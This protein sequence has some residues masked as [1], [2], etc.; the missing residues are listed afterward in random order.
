MKNISKSL[1]MLLTHREK[2]F[3]TQCKIHCWLSVPPSYLSTALRR[4]AWHQF[5]SL[6]H[7]PS[8][9]FDMMPLHPLKTRHVPPIV[10]HNSMFFILQL[11]PG[12][13]QS[14]PP[15]WQGQQTCYSMLVRQLIG[16]KGTCSLSVP[17][18]TNCTLLSLL[19]YQETNS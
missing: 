4:F 17:H 16:A 10:S 15:Y 19:V 1:S 9:S 18:K 6:S 12:Q 11:S 7:I 14:K 8:S 5:H 3:L 13:S 2:H